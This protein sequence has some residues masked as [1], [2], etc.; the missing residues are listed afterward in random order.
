M[1]TTMVMVL[2]MFNIELEFMEWIL[3]VVPLHKDQNLLTVL[4]MPVYK[5]FF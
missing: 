2:R 1:I 3:M 5:I 4:Y